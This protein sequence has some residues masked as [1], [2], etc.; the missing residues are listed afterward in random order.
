MNPQDNFRATSAQPP[1]DPSA[2][3]PS[4]GGG[5]AP[6]PYGGPPAYAPGPMMPPALQNQQL[7]GWGVRVGA[8]LIDTILAFIT[9]GIVGI[10][11]WFLGGRQ[12][13]RNGQTLGK[14]IC[15][16]RVVK[17]DG[18]PMS[19]G[20]SVIRELVVKGIAFGI[21]GLITLGILNLLDVL[22]PLWD[23]KNQTLHDKV[24]STYVVKAG[25]PVSAP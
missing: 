13:E 15:N 22:W 10:A 4:P 6:Q 21:G 19:M 11:N 12:G 18:S 23:D 24:V 9:L 3:P 8:T 20:D 17:E 2:P 14:Q 5:Y 1:S 7:A 16:I 25:Q